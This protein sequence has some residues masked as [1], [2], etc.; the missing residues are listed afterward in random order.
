[1]FSELKAISDAK[2][3]LNVFFPII[4]ETQSHTISYPTFKKCSEGVLDTYRSAEIALF[5]T[6]SEL[7]L[8]LA[9]FEQSSFKS[10]FGTVAMGAGIWAAS[11][12][13]DGFLEGLTG[14]TFNDMG[15]LA[16]VLV[17]E[18]ALDIIPSEEDLARA[19]AHIARAEACRTLLSMQND[20]FEE[21]MSERPEAAELALTGRRKF[22]EA[23]K[24]DSK[25]PSVRFGA[26]ESAPR[27]IREQFPD[28]TRREQ[29]APHPHEAVNETWKCA[30]LDITVTSPTWDRDDHQRKWKGK[31][32]DG[33]YIYFDI[34]DSSFWKKVLDQELN[35]ASPD[36]MKAQIFYLDVNGRY[37]S[38]RAERVINFNGQQISKPIEPDQLNEKLTELNSAIGPQVE[39]FR[40]DR[41]ND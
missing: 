34:T 11:E 10:W 22:F 41:Q 6:Y 35:T 3:K 15:Q 18:L 19:A 17:K 37:K 30:I 28:F 2:G 21:I 16:G 36:Q 23:C 31:L 38:A 4:F 20:A 13:G 33:K 29:I 8:E 12:F 40:I 25:I 26:T 39:L 1:M 7:E 9:A 32:G 5:G 14:K 27:I 24:T